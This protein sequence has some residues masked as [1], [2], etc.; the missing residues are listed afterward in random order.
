LPAASDR[1]WYLKRINLFHC[2]AADALE[3][4]QRAATRASYQRGQIIFGPDGPGDTIYLLETGRVKLARFDDGGREITLAILEEGEFV[5]EEALAAGHRGNSYA[6]ALDESR[7]WLLA[8]AE[9]ESVLS[10]YPDVGLA[11]ARQMSQRLLGARAQI[12]A[13]AFRDVPQRLAGVLVELA[14]KHG[15]RDASGK[16]RIQLRVTHQELASLVASTRETVT[17]LLNRFRRDGLLETE[18]RWLVLPDPEGLRAVAR[19]R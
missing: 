17:A 3:R 8:R 16:V 13:L 11:V 2:L 12:E 19:G 18:G 1:V 10:S 15:Q 9:F 5:G 14:E 6:E 7:A 4:V